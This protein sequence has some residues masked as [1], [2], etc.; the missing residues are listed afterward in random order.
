MTNEVRD[1]TEQWR[2]I[3]RVNGYAHHAHKKKDCRKIKSQRL[4]KTILRYIHLPAKNNL[5]AFEVG[6]GGG[7]HIVSLAMNSWRCV[8]IDCSKEVL[9]R[10]RHFINDIA[11]TSG[12]VLPIRLIARDFLDFQTQERFDLVFHV[13]VLEHFLNDDVRMQVLRKMFTLTRPGGYVVHIVQNGVH[14]LR[15]KM[16]QLGWGGYNIAE[17]DY[18]YELLKKELLQCAGT[19]IIVLPCN[20]FSYLTLKPSGGI[21]NIIRRLIFY[22]CQLIPVSLLPDDFAFRHSGTLIGIAKKCIS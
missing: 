1:V 21:E 17:I 8:G 18:D 2:K 9:N 10:A 19:D 12:E 14:P 11:I 22:A 4:W 3:L 13:S 16:R 20:L 15:N 5:S 7:V 6:C